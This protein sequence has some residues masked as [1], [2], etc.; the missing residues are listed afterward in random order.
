VNVCS[1]QPRTVG[2]LADALAAAMDGPRPEIVG[3][4]RPADVRHIVADP[5]QAGVLLGFT[6]GVPFGD[7]VTEFA[8]S[9]LRASAARSE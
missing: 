2:E 4:A 8:R 5:A 6:A 9:P 3:G 7:G 1:G